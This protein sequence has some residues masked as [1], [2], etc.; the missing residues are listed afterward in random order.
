M[1]KSEKILLAV[2]VVLLAVTVWFHFHPKNSFEPNDCIATLGKNQNIYTFWVVD[3]N[4]DID[5]YLMW[6]YN[7]ER[8]E[9]P[10]V[11]NADIID[12]TSEKVDCPLY[13]QQRI[14]KK[15]PKNVQW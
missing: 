10:I 6:F 1:K 9:L 15:E 3:Y 2:L 14:D 5:K 12:K 11:I 8:I 4:K 13:L 7:K